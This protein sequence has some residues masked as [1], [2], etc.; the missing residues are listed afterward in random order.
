MLETAGFYNGIIKQCMYIVKK[1]IEWRH[2]RMKL[3]AGTDFFPLLDSSKLLKYEI[4][5][6]QRRK[7]SSTC[8]EIF[9]TIHSWVLNFRDLQINFP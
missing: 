1:N 9:V 4:E 6:R 7:K 2:R 3:S 5:W 8:T